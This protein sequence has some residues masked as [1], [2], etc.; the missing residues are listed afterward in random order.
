MKAVS[1]VDLRHSYGPREALAGVCLEVPEGGLFGLLGP[2]GGGKTTIFKILSTLLRPTGGRAEVLGFDASRQPLEIRRRIGVVFQN[3]S[4]DR[5]L[6]VREN[7]LYHG[8]LYG[9][10]SGELER[11]AGELLERYR[12]ADRAGDLA[13]T[14]S[15]G[16]RRRLEL[17]K[18]L[19][20]EPKLLLLDE[21]T[22]GLDPGGRK[23]FW[24]H[25]CALRAE[26]GMTI[27]L[28]THLME[29][30]DRC[31]RLAILDRGRVIAEGAPDSLKAAIGGDVISIAT[32]DP[33]ALAQALRERFGVEASRLDGELRLER[34]QG[35]AFIPQI[36]EAFPGMIQSV[37]LGR[38]T[39]EDAFVHYTGHKFWS[40]RP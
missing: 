22:V 31:E 14:L 18:S 6:T 38:P 10:P 1:T 12:L 32:A 34:P 40:S 19:L 37:K 24:D 5:K 28:T 8:R 13:E 29:E 7:I 15:G 11:R 26:R 17:A 4:L 33:E 25:L 2:N 36:V 21:P 3:P 35:H 27:L 23:D 16:L 39:L 9:V 30:A 20:H